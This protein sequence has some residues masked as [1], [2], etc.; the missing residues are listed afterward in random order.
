MM[1]IKN[2]TAKNLQEYQMIIIQDT[3]YLDIDGFYCGENPDLHNLSLFQKGCL[4]HKNLIF[5]SI[6]KFNARN[7]TVDNLFAFSSLIS[8]SGIINT[9]I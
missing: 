5:F 7:I 4:L 1:E 6:A 2:F 9:T 3:Q 8:L